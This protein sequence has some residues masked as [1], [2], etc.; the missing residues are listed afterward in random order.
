MT[1]EWIHGIRSIIFLC[2]PKFPPVC[3][4]KNPWSSLEF[5]LQGMWLGGGYKKGFF[6]QKIGL[7]LVTFGVFR[8]AGGIYREARH[9][10]FTY[11]PPPPLVSASL[12]LR[13][14]KH[15]VFAT[16]LYMVTQI[17]TEMAEIPTKMAP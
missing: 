1:D 3:H 11:P 5:F 7:G 8:G 4:Q 6:F 15:G 13:H 10:A 14:L 9:E 12:F 2:A 17:P 16:W